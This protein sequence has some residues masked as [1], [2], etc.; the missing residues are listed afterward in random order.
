MGPTQ[1]QLQNICHVVDYMLTMFMCMSHN[2]GGKGPNSPI[3]T[4]TGIPSGLPGFL[5]RAGACCHVTKNEGDSSDPV[6][7]GSHPNRAT[8]I[9]TSKISDANLT[10]PC[11]VDQIGDGGLDLAYVSQ[12]RPIPSPGGVCPWDHPPPPWAASIT[13]TLALSKSRTGLL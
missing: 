5:R 12:V 3:L 11:K 2:K 7:C 1:F 6:S 4:Y 13:P 8:Q 10:A 9:C